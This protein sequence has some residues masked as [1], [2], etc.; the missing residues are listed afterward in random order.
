MSKY[1]WIDMRWDWGQNKQGEE[2]RMVGQR[3]GGGVDQ[4]GVQGAVGKG[5]GGGDNNMK[6]LSW[7]SHTALA[8]LRRHQIP[9]P[10]RTH[11][12]CNKEKW[13]ASRTSSQLGLRTLTFTASEDAETQR[14]S[15][16]NWNL[17]NVLLSSDSLMYAVST[18]PLT[19][20][21]THIHCC[22]HTLCSA[23]VF[24]FTF[25]YRLVFELECWILMNI[26]RMGWPAELKY[27]YFTLHTIHIR[28]G[29][30]AKSHNFS[31]GISGVWILMPTSEQS[32]FHY[33]WETK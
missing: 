26:L 14:S 13:A 16:R 15:T 20:E 5:S 2:K 22:L 10:L 28:V 11:R 30:V 32:S 25:L 33:E 6:E 9:W 12:L 19:A 7:R 1:S 3:G 27:L 8:H 23:C 21:V 18:A 24:R 17:T 4:E 31:V 29:T